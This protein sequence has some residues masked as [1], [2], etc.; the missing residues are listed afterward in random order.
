MRLLDQ[1]VSLELAKNLK[2][3]G[4]EQ[5]SVFAWVIKRDPRNMKDFELIQFP[6]EKLIR[7]V[8]SAFTAAELGEMLPDNFH[9]T[10]SGSEGTFYKTYKLQGL[11]YCEDRLDSH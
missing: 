5:K 1:V 3:L 7:E 6:V 2:D 8:Y 10:E 4:V 9:G 11:W